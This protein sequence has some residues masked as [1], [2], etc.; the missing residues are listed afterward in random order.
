MTIKY[1]TRNGKIHT[2][3]TNNPAVFELLSLMGCTV[4]SQQ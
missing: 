4:V 2:I 3:R 1:L